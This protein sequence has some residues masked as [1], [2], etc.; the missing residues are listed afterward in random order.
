MTP[1]DSAADELDQNALYSL[2][3]QPTFFRSGCLDDNQH[4]R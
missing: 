3:T 4:D 1:R 2:L